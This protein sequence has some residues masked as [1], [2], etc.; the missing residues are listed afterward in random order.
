MWF[1]RRSRRT[2]TGD[3]PQW[4]ETA[5][6]VAALATG[7]AAIAALLFTQQSIAA[8][9]DELAITRK[10]MAV[11]ERG[12]VSERFGQAIEQLGADTLDVRLGGIYALER[13]MRDSPKDQPTVIEVLS[14]YVRTRT[15]VRSDT[16]AKHR[17]RLDVDIQAALTVLGRRDNNRDGNARIDLADADLAGADLTLADLAFANLSDADLSNAELEGA[18]LSNA[19]LHGAVLDDANLSDAVLTC[20]QVNAATIWPNGAAPPGDCPG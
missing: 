13:L 6:T 11:N 9:Q 8:T 1:V 20:V 3:R 19:D 2:K 16:P 10:Q 17:V 12:Q 15:P 14:A 18:D 4:V 7:I 5:Q